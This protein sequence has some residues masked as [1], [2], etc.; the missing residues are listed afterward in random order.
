[1]NVIDEKNRSRLLHFE[2]AFELTCL[3]TTTSTTEDVRIQIAV[4]G[5]LGNNACG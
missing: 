2:C 5:A 3:Q 1:V 4:A